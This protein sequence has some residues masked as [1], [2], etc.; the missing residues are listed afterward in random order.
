MQPNRLPQKEPWWH[1]SSDEL[2]QVWHGVSEFFIPSVRRDLLTI[3]FR[4]DSGKTSGVEDGS[5]WSDGTIIVYGRED[6]ESQGVS[7]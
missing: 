7:R 2:R 5:G 6:D 3:T 4:S 1:I